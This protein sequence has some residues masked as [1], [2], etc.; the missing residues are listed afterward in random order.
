M[1]KRKRFDWKQPG[2]QKL[3]ESIVHGAVVTEGTMV[4]FPTCFPAVT[5]PVVAD[6]SRITALDIT[7]SGIVYAGTSGKAS[8]LLV[9]M[10]HGITGVV[11]DM[12]VVEGA[13]QCAAFCCGEKN[14]AA[15]VNGPAGGRLA[16]RHLQ[17]LPFDLIQEWHMTRSPYKF[18]APV[19]GERILHAVTDAR[20][21]EVVGVTDKHLFTFDF[22]TRKVAVVGEVPG[23]ARLARG[24]D[25][26]I[27]G[28]DGDD[29]LWR[30]DPR[31]RKLKRNAVRLP[32]GDWSGATLMWARDD[33]N[34]LLYLADTRGTL[35]SLDKKARFSRA[36]AKLPL[37]PIGAMAVTRDG[38]LFANAGDGIARMSCYDPATRKARDL[39]VAV[40]I[41]ERRRYGYCFGDAVVGRDGELVFGEN[42][43]LGHLWL[44]FPSIL[45]RGRS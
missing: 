25:G 8:H 1:K 41:M 13:D 7:A 44:Y 15:A 12:G 9:F 35:F 36:L 19:P 37:T 20:R 33:T 38:R 11:F 29:T 42:D 2:A 45:A 24:P 16:V 28:R 14:Y 3:A 40:S 21:K 34:G 31:T 43:D 6:E 26:A 32:K 22:E 18:V 27:F 4:A 30:F 17:P 23:A 39:G 5:I 10:Y